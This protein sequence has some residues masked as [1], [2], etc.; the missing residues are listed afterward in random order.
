MYIP[1]SGG[2]QNSNKYDV[3][4]ELVMECILYKPVPGLMTYNQGSIS[5]GQY[6]L[7]TPA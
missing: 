6:I 7:A 4:L 2:Q 3:S 1:V 5:V